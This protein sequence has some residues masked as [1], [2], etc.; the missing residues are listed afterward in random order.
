MPENT[1]NSESF[2]TTPA[3]SST[4][5]CRKYAGRTTIIHDGVIGF[6]DMGRVIGVVED[7]EGNLF[8]PPRPI[9]AGQRKVLEEVGGLVELSPK[10]AR[11]LPLH[12]ENQRRHDVFVERV[13]EAI[14]IAR[15]E[16]RR[17]PSIRETQKVLVQMGHPAGR[18]EKICEQIWRL[19]NQE[20]P[21]GGEH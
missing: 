15:R 7:A 20:D 18:K 4:L 19:R 8:D 12:L 17:W 10:E 6:D 14:E 13:T 5:Y 2:T 1:E 11:E 21:Q 16:L 3:H 9:S